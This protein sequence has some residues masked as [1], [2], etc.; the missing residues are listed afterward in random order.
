MHYFGIGMALLITIIVLFIHFAIKETKFLFF[1]IGIAVIVAIA[2]FFMEFLIETGRQKEKETEFLEFCRDLAEGVSVGVPISKSILKVEDKDYGSL[3][4]HIKKLAN[5]ISL[6]I[7]FRKALQVFARDTKN[8]IISRSANI[9]IQ[10]EESGGKIGSILDNV[11]KGVREIEDIKKERKSAMYGQV[12]QGYV[13]FTI[14]LVIILV[15]QLWLIPQMQEITQL[16]GESEI[17][18]ESQM[19]FESVGFLNNSLLVLL[20][21]Q[22]FFIGLVIGQLSEGN[23][24]SGIKHSVILLVLAYLIVSIAHALV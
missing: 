16:G 17:G 9:I 22:S 12:I 2:P 20:F 6:G 14:F 10:A 13:I 7:P 21:I 19:S 3:S 5:Q 24:R 23:I 18:G 11:A 8:K 15:L 4:P 1:F